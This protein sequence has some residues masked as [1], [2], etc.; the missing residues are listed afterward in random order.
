M[1]LCLLNI[2]SQIRETGSFIIYARIC[3]LLEQQQS[4]NEVYIE[5]DKQ[6]LSQK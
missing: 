2:A 3:A 4:G 6:P 1:N 5:K